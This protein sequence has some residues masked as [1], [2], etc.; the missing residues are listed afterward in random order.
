MP[1]TEWDG[2]E[3]TARFRSLRAMLGMELG[4]A[5][6]EREGQTSS[7]FTWQ[8]GSVWGSAMLNGKFVLFPWGK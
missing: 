8:R 2:R 7:Y 5:P 4:G 1:I 3:L 6:A